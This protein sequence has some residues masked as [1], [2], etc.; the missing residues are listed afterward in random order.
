MEN[1]FTV[2]TSTREETFKLHFDAAKAELTQK[3]KDA[4][5]QTK[6]YIYS[7]CVSAEVAAE[8]AKRFNASSTKA[9]VKA[10]WFRARHLEIDVELPDH[11]RPPVEEKKVAPTVEVKVEEKKEEEKKEEEK[12]EEVVEAAP[13][14]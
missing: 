13:V 14:A 9:V 10:P 8:L 1:L 4:P 6:F 12:K 11:L 2:A 5:L 7:G 3:I